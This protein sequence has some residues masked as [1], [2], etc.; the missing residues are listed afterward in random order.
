MTTRSHSEVIFRVDASKA[1]GGKT[2]MVYLSLDLPAVTALSVSI[3][4]VIMDFT[5]ILFLC[6]VLKTKFQKKI[7]SEEHRV[8]HLS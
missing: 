4:T 2:V 8:Y 5:A 3:L 7:L 6:Q 1:C